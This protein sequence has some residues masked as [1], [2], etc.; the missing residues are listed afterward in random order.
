M[1]A[2]PVRLGYVGCGFVA[3]NV[4]LP[5]FAGLEGCSLVALAERRPQ[6]ARLVAERFGIGRVYN[7]HLELA[8]DPEI[9]AVAL[10][11]GFSEQGEIA[12]DI[13]RAGKHVFMEKPM[14]LSLAQAE[15]ILAAEQEGGARLMVAYMKRYDPGNALAREIISS[16]QASGEHGRVTY[17]RGHGFCGDWTAGLDTGHMLGTD[18]QIESMPWAPAIPSWLTDEKAAGNYVWYLQ[19]WIHNVN[20]LRFLLGAGDDCQVRAV[21]LNDDGQTG[22]VTIAMG[23]VRALVES[24]SVDY[25]HWEEHTQVYFEGGWVHVWSP[26]LL[27]PSTQARVE[28]Y[29]G[30][31]RHSYSYPVPEPSTGWAYREEA[32]HFIS[33]VR[34]GEEFRSSGQDTLTDI[35]LFEDI[36]RMYLG[37][38]A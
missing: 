11:A 20:L 15:R 36:Y 2:G 16:W 27:I 17:A 31:E 38:K 18:E 34:S 35:R 1:D 24:G 22:L 8:A 33:A 26:P 13:L 28:C 7:S 21:D 30:G 23:G 6:L 25:H 5:N 10:S 32:A 14:A 37:I 3:Q 19:Q 9:E 12:A 29:V 4:H